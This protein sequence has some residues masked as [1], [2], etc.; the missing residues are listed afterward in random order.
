V[1]VTTATELPREL[2]GDV[3]AAGRSLAVNVWHRALL[4][5][6]PR[7]PQPASIG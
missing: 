1:E 7:P 4:V 6:A 2:D 3:I 5:R